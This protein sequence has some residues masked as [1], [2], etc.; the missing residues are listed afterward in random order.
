VISISLRPSLE[1]S[2]A[3]TLVAIDETS[4]NAENAA[5][6]PTGFAEIVSDVALM[7]ATISAHVYEVRPRREIFVTFYED[8][9]H[10]FSGYRVA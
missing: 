8:F 6:T 4:S 1:A 9:V 3:E 7:I 5:P 2:S 10:I